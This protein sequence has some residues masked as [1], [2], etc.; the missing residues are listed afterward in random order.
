MLIFIIINQLTLF[1]FITIN[2]SINF[3]YLYHYQSINPLCLYFSLSINHTPTVYTGIEYLV[4]ILGTWHRQ[5]Y[6]NQL[7][8]AILLPFNEPHI[9]TIFKVK[10]SF[11]LYPSFYNGENKISKF[12]APPS[13]V[14]ALGEISHIFM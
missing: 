14:N 9:Y 4:W 5:N 8:S 7:A 13:F 12:M 1:I 10:S 6:S 3:G 11:F 2:Q